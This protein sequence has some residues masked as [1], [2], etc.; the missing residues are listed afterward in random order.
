MSSSLNL[1]IGRV[2]TLNY[3]LPVGDIVLSKL[4]TSFKTFLVL[5]GNT[6]KQRPGILTKAFPFKTSSLYLT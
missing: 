1:F 5:L 2:H 4:S 3:K 6:L